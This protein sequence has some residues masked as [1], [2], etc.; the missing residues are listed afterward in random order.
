MSRW[1]VLSVPDLEN[2]P[3]ADLIH[4]VET[5]YDDAARAEAAVLRATALA[6][7][8]VDRGSSYATCGR[9]VLEALRG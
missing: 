1:R 2:M 7:G 3:K 5:A 8:W 6:Q 4:M 9:Q